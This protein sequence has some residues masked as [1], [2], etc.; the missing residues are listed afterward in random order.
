MTRLRIITNVRGLNSPSKRGTLRSEAPPWELGRA[1]F[2]RIKLL[3]HPT[4]DEKSSTKARMEKDKNEMT[5]RILNLTLEII[6]QLT[7]EDYTI[8]KN[9][10]AH[11]V[12]PRIHPLVSAER[13]KC[14][15]IHERNN[16]QKVLELTNKI[17]E[18]LTGEVPIRCQDVTVHFSME[19][20]EY[21]DGHKDLYEDIMME[22]HQPFTL[23]DGSSKTNPPERCPSPLS[24]QDCPEENHSVPENHQLN[25]DEDLIDIKIEVID[26][27]EEDEFLKADQLCKEDDIP[28]DIRQNLEDANGAIQSSSGENSTCP[29]I[30]SQLLSSDSSSYSSNTKRT[31]DQSPTYRESNIFPFPEPEDNFTEKSD[32]NESGQPSTWESYIIEHQ[33][34][35]TGEKSLPY[36]NDGKYLPQRPNL[37]NQQRANMGPP[38]FL[39]LECGKWFPQE[40]DLLKHQK[41]HTGEKPFSCAECGKS[42]AQKSGLFEHQKLHTGKKPFSCSDCGRCFTRK[43][44]LV[45]HGRIHTGEKPFVCLECG[46]CFTYKSGLSEHEKIHTGERPFSCSVCGKCFNKRAVLVNHLRTHTGERPFPCPECGKCFTDKSVLVKHQ[47]IHTGEKP[48]SCS[49]CGRCFTQKSVLDKHQRIHKGEKPFSCSECGRC[50]TQKSVLMKHQRIHTGDRPFLYRN[51]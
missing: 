39:C 13:S 33:R 11:F 28:A 3:N 27:D 38:Q 29:N 50:F 2:G 22:N 16:K 37:L 15:R 32:S 25:P 34:H 17:V 40:C 42:Y 6:Y 9:T 41:I 18:L 8:V 30:H 43:S 51:M 23:P 5:K 44:S 1:E 21:L 12:I 24:S 47:R 7:G 19:E 31:S 49:E 48:F 20:W 4:P 26:G 46:K 35:Y 45:E 36:T 14:Q 10:T